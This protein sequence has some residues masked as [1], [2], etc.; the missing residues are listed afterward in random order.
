M[1]NPMTHEYFL[2]EITQMLA[3]VLGLEPDEISPDS[4]MVNDL[5]AE[6]LDFVEFNANLEKRFNF[7]LPK[8]GALL[9]AGKIS[10]SPELFYSSKTGLTNDG[11]ELLKQ[12]LSHYT[13]LKTGA[14]ISDIFNS[15]RVV[16]IASLCHN[17]FS[18]YLPASCPDCGHTHARLSPQGK[19][20]CE[21]CSTPVRP[22]HGD[23][24]EEQGLRKYLEFTLAE[25]V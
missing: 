1:K 2:T 9:Q 14:S 20:V 11:V 21:Q 3:D 15:T 13:H 6:S 4:E 23:E 22:L 5:G 24:A 12:C 25:A 10:G 7:V 16:N 19:L 8:K 18:Q 17:L